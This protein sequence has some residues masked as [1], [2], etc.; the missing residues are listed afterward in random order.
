MK[1]LNFHDLINQNFNVVF[2][3][4]L[5]QYWRGIKYFQ[6][7]G[8][9]KKQ[10]LFLFLDGYEITYTDKSGDIAV[11]HSGDVVYAPVG[12][13]YR[14]DLFKSDDDNAHTIGINFMLLNEEGEPVRLSDTIQVFH[15]MEESNIS[16]LFTQAAN[17]D[18]ERSYIQKRILLF[19]IIEMLSPENKIQRNKS[20][21]APGLNYLSGHIGENPC[22]AV[23][24]KE[25]SIS[26]GYFRKVFK[27]CV[28]MSP[29][30]YRNKLRLDRAST[31]LEYGD[32]SV[33][34]ISDTLG[35]STV[36]HFIKEFKKF[37]GVSPLKYRKRFRTSQ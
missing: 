16:M 35:Y 24:A 17:D 37:Y 10:N 27:D 22:V 20:L 9:P 1:T 7:V 34:E 18:F 36:S 25:C 3:N 30:E 12:S 31:Y 6:C 32:I 11:A 15:P 29:V 23:L 8:E 4:A 2:L 5:Q 14:A 26:E 33:Q 19:R 21:I 13:E 28:K